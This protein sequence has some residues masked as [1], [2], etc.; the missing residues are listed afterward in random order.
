M[1][2]P[3]TTTRER[4]RR[5]VCRRSKRGIQA[6][7]QAASPDSHMNP[8]A[9]CGRSSETFHGPTRTTVPPVTAITA[10]AMAN[11]DAR[12]AN[13]RT[14]RDRQG[15]LYRSADAFR[16]RS[17]SFGGQAALQFAPVTAIG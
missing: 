3:A 17:A 9:F 8:S 4:R 16:L 2:T 13:E 14:S 10:A 5:D 6:T 11:V 12:S 15:D 7:V 1:S